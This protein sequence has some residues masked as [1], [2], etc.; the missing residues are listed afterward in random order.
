M[1]WLFAYAPSGH[2]IYRDWHPYCYIDKRVER[3]SAGYV[4]H[5]LTSE[6]ERVLGF[7]RINIVLVPEGTNKV[8]QFKIPRFLLVLLVLALFPCATL[9]GLIARE[10]PTMKFQM[11]RVAQLKKENEQQ[12]RQLVH[13][14]GQITQMRQRLVELQEFDQRLRVMVSLETSEDN[15]SY[16]GVGGSGPGPDQADFSLA[17]DHRELV[18]LMHRSLENLKNDIAFDKEEKTELYLFLEN[19]KHLLACTPSIWPTKGW[20]SSSFGHRISPFT[21]ERE[22]HDGIDISTR[23]NAPIVAPADG[24]VSSVSRGHTSGKTLAIR[25]GY[26]VR[27]IYAHLQKSL[28]KKG[29]AVKRGE[30]IALVGNTGRSTGPHLHYEVHVNGVPTNPRRYILN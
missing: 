20:L 11:P 29:Q 2:D 28:V 19:Q 6:G 1:T 12:K 23:L 30:T 3:L 22:F 21:G 5:H 24:I 16:E 14:A 7:K 9:L 10:Y 15:S 13:L 25:H 18:R 27:T 17:K 4:L 26:G 8:K